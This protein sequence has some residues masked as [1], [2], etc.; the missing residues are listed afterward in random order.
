M[1]Q[2]QRHKPRHLSC[3]NQSL[4]GDGCP[5]SGYW[6]CEKCD[7]CPVQDTE[8]LVAWFGT[9]MG[10][11]IRMSNSP[12]GRDNDSECLAGSLNEEVCCGGIFI[13]FL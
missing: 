5:S 9:V 3:D 13:G 12:I 11:V 10:I 6:S 8:A 2:G 1:L 4:I 7:L